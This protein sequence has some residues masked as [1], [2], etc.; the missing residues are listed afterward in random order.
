M[1]L[2]ILAAKAVMAVFSLCRQYPG[3]GEIKDLAPGPAVTVNSILKSRDI[4][5]PTKV[6]LVKA[7]VFPVVMY[8]YESWTVKKAECQR[9]DAVVLE[10]T[11][12]SPLDCKE[13]QPVHSRGDQS[14]VFFGRNDAK[15]EAP[16]LWPSDAKY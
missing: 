14:W 13:I 2:L 7:M 9:I 3:L 8:G 6:R 10:K 4:T 12:E 5:L 16:I 15:T 11:L 1:D